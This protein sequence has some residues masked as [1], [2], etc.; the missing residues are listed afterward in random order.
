MAI[1]PIVIQLEA[2]RG[3]LL[4]AG[5]LLMAARPFPYLRGLAELALH[6]AIRLRS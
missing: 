5:L 3:W 6:K 1:G 4:V 2:R